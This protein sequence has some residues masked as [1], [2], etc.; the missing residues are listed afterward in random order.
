MKRFTLIA[1]A[2]SACW[3]AGPTPTAPS[4]AEIIFKV[5]PTYNVEFC[6]SNERYPYIGDVAFGGEFAYVAE[7]LFQPPAF[8]CDGNSGGDDMTLEPVPVH[9][10]ALDSG[11]GPAFT[12]GTSTGTVTTRV[13]GTPSRGGWV[14]SPDD[15]TR[16][17]LRGIGGPPEAD[18]PYS[19]GFYVPVGVVG[20]DTHAFV[21]AT[22]GAS[23][24]TP[25]VNSPRYPCCTSGTNTNPSSP[26]SVGWKVSWEL[27]ET[28]IQIS[29]PTETY[30]INDTLKSG[31]VANS[32]T[33]FYA[34]R[35]RALTSLDADLRS[36]PKTDTTEFSIRAQLPA[37]LGILVGLAATDA[38]LAWTIAPS[39]AKLPI[40]DPQ[41]NVYLLDLLNPAE[42]RTPHFSTNDFSCQDLALDDTH[43][44]FMIVDVRQDDNSDH[45][46]GDMRG[47]GIGRVSLTSPAVV[48]SITIGDGDSRFSGP[49]RIYVHGDDLY[50]VD[51]FAIAR[52]SK[53]AL[54]NESDF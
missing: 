33:V 28:P 37:F 17:E 16:V 53:N 25:D 41:C 36:M 30:V 47:I 46:P 32:T 50:L 3:G 43:A 45:N 21:V 13:A 38:V 8:N 14:H 5:A 15:G 35:D 51:P 31:V 7:M 6:G 23:G 1:I 10:I 40:P 48:E 27:T 39:Y 11:D 20:D 54:D 29:L 42:V 44:Y 4:N 34:M 18:L 9:R 2:S 49:R 24:V 26:A 52:V 19:G 12:A 22:T